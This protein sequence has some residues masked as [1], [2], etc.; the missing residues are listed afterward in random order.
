MLMAPRESGG[1]RNENGDNP[2]RV[3]L[4]FIPNIF[5]QSQHHSPLTT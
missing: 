2:V 4:L 5:H 1:N 3:E